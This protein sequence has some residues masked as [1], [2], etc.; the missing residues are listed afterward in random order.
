MSMWSNES[1]EVKQ[2]PLIRKTINGTSYTNF[3]EKKYATKLFTSH[4]WY[5]IQN[6]LCTFDYSHNFMNIWRIVFGSIDS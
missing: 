6:F 4:A 1:N 2:Q 3:V 5:S